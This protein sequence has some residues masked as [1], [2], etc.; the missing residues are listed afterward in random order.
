MRDST[1]GYPVEDPH[2]IGAGRD[3]TTFVCVP[4]RNAAAGRFGAQL[5]G[6]PGWPSPPDA[7]ADTGTATTSERASTAPTMTARSRTRC[8]RE[9]TG[10]APL[11]RLPRRPLPFP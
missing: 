7:D 6:M 1:A 2:G 4:A 10:A 8:P 11:P 5:L 3:G 9:P